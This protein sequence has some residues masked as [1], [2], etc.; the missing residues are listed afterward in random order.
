[1]G[2]DA[3]NPEKREKHKK[4]RKIISVGPPFFCKMALFLGQKQPM[5]KRMV[6]K[7]LMY[8]FLRLPICRRFADQA[9]ECGDLAKE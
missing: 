2:C 8:S 7:L 3:Q 5:K 6:C 4:K 1:M 9:G